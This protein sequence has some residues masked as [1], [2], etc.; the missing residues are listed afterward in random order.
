MGDVGE[1]LGVLHLQVCHVGEG[2]HQLH[3]TGP[4]GV[5]PALTHGAFHLGVAAVAD[6]DGLL[7]IL[8]VSGDLQVD[9]GHQGAGGVEDTQV[10][11]GGLCT[12]L[13]GHPVGTEDDR[14]PVR[15]LVQFFDK[16]GAALAQVLDHEAVVDH[17]M[18]DID[19]GPEELD[20]PLDDVDGSVHAGAKA[21]RV[22]DDDIHG[23]WG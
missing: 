15:D 2:F 10:A 9:L 7:A 21:P 16:N 6:E 1:V 22:G 5:A 12:H 23:A 19:G 8:A 20:G 13:L 18:A 4:G 14:G 17:L 11:P 3:P